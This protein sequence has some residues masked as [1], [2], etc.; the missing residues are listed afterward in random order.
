MTPVSLAGHYGRT[1]AID[2]CHGCNHVWFDGHEDLHL[3]PGA[4]VTLFEELGRTAPA[5]RTAVA[6][7]KPCPR[8][9]TGLL[10]T[11][12]RVKAT[13]YEFFRCSR[14]HGRLMSFSA[15]LR[16]KHFVRDLTDDEVR[17]LRVDARVIK[18]VNCG[19]S[20]D[21][22][23]H[24]ACQYCKATIAI[25]DADQ[26]TKTLAALEQAEAR[27]AT[28]DP[29]W[30]LRVEQARRQTE[31]AFQSLQREYGSTPDLDLVEIG[32]VQ[33]AKIARGLLGSLRPSAG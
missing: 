12:D 11:H 29:T 24:S 25:L 7:R 3:S 18:C 15:F 6:A 32:L 8:C 33:F 13:R 27:R 22:S 4:V 19:A 1:V 23:S 28:L 9:G 2:V 17:T 21:I 31:A 20:T 14:D 10:R 26:L 16:A 5:A 30:P